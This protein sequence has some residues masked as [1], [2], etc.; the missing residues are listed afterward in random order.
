MNAKPNTGGAGFEAEKANV[1][2]GKTTAVPNLAAIFVGEVAD[3]IVIS[4]MSIP[5]MIVRKGVEAPAV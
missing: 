3:A 5:S 4:S 1:E 2:V